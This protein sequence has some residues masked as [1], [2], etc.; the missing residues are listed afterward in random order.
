[1][2]SMHVCW[3]TSQ[4]LD[5]DGNLTLE[6]GLTPQQGSEKITGNVAVLVLEDE[7]V[8]IVEGVETE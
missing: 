3:T 4:S 8:E 7:G 5:V 6:K 2:L 1:M